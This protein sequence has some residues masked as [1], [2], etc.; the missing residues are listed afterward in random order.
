MDEGAEAKDR[1]V[2]SF[3]EVLDRIELCHVAITR[4]YGCI[5][6]DQYELT[7]HHPF[8]ATFRDW[9]ESRG[10][11]R[12]TGALYVLD[13]Q[14]RYQLTVAPAAGRALLV[15]RLSLDLSLQREAALEVARALDQ[16]L[17]GARAPC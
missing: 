17:D 16:L 4:R 2:A 5:R 8:P 15:P 3:G 10:V 6:R 12:Q 9:L 14:S 11:L 1:S 13:A 7:A